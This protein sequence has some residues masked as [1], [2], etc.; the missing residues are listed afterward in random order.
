MN[1]YVLVYILISTFVW[2]AGGIIMYE[3]LDIQSGFPSI[4]FLIISLILQFI[5]YHIG[6]T[7]IEKSMEEQK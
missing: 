2:I 3:V 7:I 6:T 4:I 1:I 5:M